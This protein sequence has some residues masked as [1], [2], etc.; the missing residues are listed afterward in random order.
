MR[1][2]LILTLLAEKEGKNE[3]DCIIDN[4]HACENSR[5]IAFAEN[6]LEHR[7]YIGEDGTRRC[8][9]CDAEVK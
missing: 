8:F 1:M 5:C 2:A 9:Y 6:T 7:F 4:E 3:P